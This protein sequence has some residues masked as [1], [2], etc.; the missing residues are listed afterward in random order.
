MKTTTPKTLIERLQTARQE[1]V[2]TKIVLRQAKN[3][4]GDFLAWFASDCDYDGGGKNQKAREIA[5]AKLLAENKRASELEN[6]VRKA[7][8]ENDLTQCALDC[9]LDE[10]KAGRD[11]TWTILAEWASAHTASACLRRQGQMGSR[12]RAGQEMLKE[13]V[14]TALNEDLG[15]GRTPYGEQIGRTSQV[16]L[17]PEPGKDEALF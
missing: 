2:A 7:E 12:E 17:L 11:R 5:F 15:Y 9:V 16:S 4:V 13:Q 1:A 10:V 3:D 14:E 8:D 6:A